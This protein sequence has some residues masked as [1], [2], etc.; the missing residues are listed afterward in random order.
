[1]FLIFTL[2]SNF[3]FVLAKGMYIGAPCDE[4]CNSNLLHVYCEESTKLCGC[5][6]NYP[7]KLGLTKGCAKRMS[8]RFYYF[9]MFL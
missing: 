8:F 3:F 2:N 5:E 1:M 6:R 7:V 9:S 4:S